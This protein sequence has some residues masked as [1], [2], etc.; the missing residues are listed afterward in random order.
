MTL[1][2]PLIILLMILTVGCSRKK[3]V[4]SA[5]ANTKSIKVFKEYHFNYP[6]NLTILEADSL[7]LDGQ[8]YFFVSFFINPNEF[9]KNIT[10]PVY[11]FPLNNDG[12]LSGE[13]FE[14]GSAEHIRHFSKLITPWGEGIILSDHGV[15]HPT[16]N[17]GGKILL[18]VKNKKTN[19][20]ED[21]SLRLGLERNFS[22]NVVAP[23]RK[24]SKYNDILILP[25]NT[26]FSRV[27]YLQATDNGYINLSQLLPREWVNKNV[28]YMTG[29]AIDLHHTGTDDV[30]LGGCDQDSKMNPT[31]VDRIIS[32]NGKRWMWNL[33]SS[34]PL[35][36]KGIGWGT[37]FLMKADLNQTGYEDIVALTHD[38]GFH[39]GF[40]QILIRD[41]DHAKIIFNNSKISNWPSALL[42]SQN[43]LHKVISY[44]IDGDG[45][46]D[47]VGQI[48]YIDHNYIVEP[49][50]FVLMNKKDHWEYRENVFDL[51]KNS[52]VVSIEKMKFNGSKKDSLVF[53]FYNGDLKIF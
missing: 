15:D 22:F 19:K 48:N 2:G 49:N 4:P 40:P 17:K 25:Y 14:F 45:L 42:K 16:L 28:C 50:I 10:H 39:Q 53:I 7:E 21:M 52:H 27:V 36:E 12:S 32:W 34:I 1:R 5:P 43:Y 38:W 51:P 35:R 33:N 24:N 26:T 44:D 8:K 9:Y 11:I 30:F 29:V 41:K 23:K 13:H 18:I 37:V 46:P 31:R 6:K 47:L 3:D 20:L